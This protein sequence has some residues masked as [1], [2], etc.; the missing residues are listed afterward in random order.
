M[1]TSGC[2][3]VICRVASMPL[4]NGPWP[5]PSGR[6]AVRA[7]CTVRSL[8]AIGCFRPRP[9]GPLRFLQQRLHAGANKRVIFRQEQCVSV[10]L[11]N[12]ESPDRDHLSESPRRHSNRLVSGLGRG[13]SEGAPRITRVPCPGLDPR[14]YRA[15]GREPLANSRQTHPR[16]PLRPDTTATSKPLPSSPLRHDRP[17]G[18]S[19]RHHDSLALRGGLRYS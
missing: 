7:S 17:A 6:S 4:A 2:C 3:A 9:A 13:I 1:R 10:I 18:S 16:G 5:G 11:Q 19:E 12:S 8:L 14:E 15:H